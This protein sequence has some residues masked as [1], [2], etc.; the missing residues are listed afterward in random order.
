[1]LAHL[2]GIK[3]SGLGLGFLMDIFAISSGEHYWIS[4]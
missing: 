1:L 3:L 4:G 2:V